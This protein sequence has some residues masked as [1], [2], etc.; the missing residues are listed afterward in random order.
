MGTNVTTA[1]ITCPQNANE[2]LGIKLPFLVM[3]IK[4][5]IHLP[6]SSRSILPSRFKYSMTKMC[7]VDLGHPTINLQRGWNPS[8]APCLWGL[9]KVGTRFSSIFLTS[10]GEHTGVIIL[11]RCVSPSTPTAVLEGS[12]SLIDSIVNN[13]SLPSSNSFF[14]FRNSSESDGIFHLYT[15]YTQSFIT[16]IH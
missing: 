13:N 16:I 4:N 6:F 2:T 12:T 7:V 3:I 10:Q 11:R 8:S 15:T 14:P 1:F 9:T 5:V